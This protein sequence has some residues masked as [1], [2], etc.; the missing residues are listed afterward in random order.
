VTRLA[1]LGGSAVATPQLAASVASAGIEDLEFALVGRSPRKLALVA[2]A[3]RRA[4]GGSVVVS[5][6][7][8]PTSALDG[9]DVILCQVRI[10]GLQGRTFDE[11]YARDLGVPGEE[12]VGP[13]GFALAWRTLPALRPLFDT[14]RAV[15]PGAV[16]LNLTNPAAMVHRLASR[17]LRTITL[18]DAPIVLGE[19]VA[20]MVGADPGGTD[21]RYSGLNHCGWITGL[22][23]AGDELLG[24]ALERPVELERLTGIDA[25]LTSA[26]GAI[27]NPYLRYLYHPDRQLAAQTS[28][29]RVRAEELE[30][31][32]EAALSAYAD[33]QSDLS[34]I[35]S[36]R[37]A[38]WYSKSV[39]PLL[40][41]LVSGQPL[42]TVANVTNG[43]TLPFLPA[44]ATVEVAVEIDGGTVV[45]LPADPLAADLRAILASVA[46]FDVFAFDGILDNDMS[47][48][49]R[50]LRA[51]PLVSSVDMARE[52]LGRVKQQFGPPSERVR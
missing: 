10:G 22:G 20:A 24:A 36:A 26:T 3:C 48:C 38:P 49:V 45:P 8:E 43:D 11:Q 21:L 7:S 19:N 39:V 9:A 51:H 41:A 46:A 32:E 37:P 27:P 44:E 6:H 14:C 31:L 33:A 23:T 1:V 4:G 17:Y 52:L 47:T 16:L 34:A 40:R 35:A 18:C 13:G 15:A 29:S 12:T 28:R 5:E 30:E 42:H 2:G 50:A 25:E